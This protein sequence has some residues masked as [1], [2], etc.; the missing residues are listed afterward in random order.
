MTTNIRHAT[1]GALAALMVAGGGIAAATSGHAH[2]AHIARRHVVKTVGG[3]IFKPNVSDTFTMRFVP[4]D[5]TVHTGDTVVF[6]KADM[7]SDPHSVSLVGPGD[8][9]RHTEPCPECDRVEKA[10]FPHGQTQPP[11]P[12]VNVGRPGFDGPGDSIVWM[13][14]RTSVKVTAPAGTVLH[15]FCA[16]HP[17]MQGTITVVK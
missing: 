4:G 1:V 16:L 15:Y 13:K 9:P 3:E 17:W 7:G 12:V 10:H 6:D 11:L 14:G 5:V 8:L 2:Q